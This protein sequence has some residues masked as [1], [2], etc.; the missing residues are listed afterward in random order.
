VLLELKA[1][2]KKLT[3]VDLSGSSDKSKKQPGN[4]KKE[5]NVSSANGSVQTAD[6]SAREVKKVTRLVS[7]L[8]F[9]VF[10]IWLRYQQL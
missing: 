2:Y 8:N 9:P 1:E 3:G 7:A 10:G 5:P 4:S 6:S